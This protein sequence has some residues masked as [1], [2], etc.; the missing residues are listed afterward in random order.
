[1]VA[2]CTW[3]GAFLPTEAEW[4][5][6]ARGR[7]AGRLYPWGNDAPVKPPVGTNP[8]R[9]AYEC[10]YDSKGSP[11]QVCSIDS[12]AR[13]GVLT[14]GMNAGGHYDMA[15]NVGEWTL[16]HHGPYPPTCVDCVQRTF[17]TLTIARGG[18]FAG[19]IDYLATTHRGAIETESR[20]NAHGARCARRP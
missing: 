3:D 10:L 20:Y 8:T 16:D 19:P 11:T 12:F 9:A 15:G 17:N 5:W 1:M 18:T 14:A 6:A 4:E 2:F 13:P 7:E